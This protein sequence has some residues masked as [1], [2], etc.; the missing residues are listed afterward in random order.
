MPAH[1]FETGAALPY[2]LKIAT[3]NAIL[4]HDVLGLDV[5][6]EDAIPVHVIH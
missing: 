3:G 2:A 6:M 4:T 5:A 1:E